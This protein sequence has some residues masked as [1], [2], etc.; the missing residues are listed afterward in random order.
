MC[1]VCDNA[2]CVQCKTMEPLVA[3]KTGQQYHP[4]FAFVLFHPSHLCT[5]QIA[6][7][8]LR[9]VRVFGKPNPE[10]YRLAEQLLVK[11]WM[12]MGNQVTHLQGDYGDHHQQQQ[13]QNHHRQHRQHG[14]HHHDHHQKHRE[15]AHANPFSAIYAVGDNPAAD[16][17]GANAAG[18][19]WVSVLVHTGVFQP[20]HGIV[21]CQQDPAEIVVADVDAAVEA[22]L[23]R[24]RHETWHALR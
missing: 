20:T 4:L 23:H 3:R 15:T 18:H 11:Q 17:R 21:N 1:C 6:G 5:T 16:V 14:H 7:I 2:M 13:H 22:A 12:M 24:Q 9:D 8:P 19:P 10:P